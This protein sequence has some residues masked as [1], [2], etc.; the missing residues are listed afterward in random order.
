[1][2]AHY[3]IK[4]EDVRNDPCKVADSICYDRYMAQNENMAFTFLL[5]RHHTIEMNWVFCAAYMHCIC[6]TT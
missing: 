4:P 1:M 6:S 2:A 5:A 3:L